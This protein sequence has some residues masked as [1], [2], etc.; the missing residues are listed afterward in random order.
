[1]TD[2][3]LALAPVILASAS[4][5]RFALLTQ[6]G[7]DVTRIPAQVDEEA[8]RESLQG[9]GAAPREIA[10]LLAELKARNV[11]QRHGDAVVIGADQILICD[12]RLFAKPRD[13]TEAAR[14]LAAFSGKT[15]ELVT[16]VCAAR[17]GEVIWRALETPRL[18][19]RPLS[20][21]FI[22]SYL[23]AAGE[24]VFGSVGVYHLEGLGAQLF[25]RIDGDYF[26]ILGLP[27]IQLLDFLRRH[28]IVAT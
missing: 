21:G 4:P 7:L 13:R 23:D 3:R 16:A 11:S 5:S 15:H 19:M 9:E 14:H 8:V 6:A 1:M 27:L 26:S 2:A 25:T 22:E 12:G 10:D 24:A 18:T 20:A 17:G 28:N